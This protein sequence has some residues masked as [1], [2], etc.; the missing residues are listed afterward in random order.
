MQC[1]KLSPWAPASWARLGARPSPL[2]KPPKF[3]LL[4]DAVFIMWWVFFLLAKITVGAMAIAY[5]FLLTTNSFPFFNICCTYHHRMRDSGIKSLN[6]ILMYSHS[7]TIQD[8]T[9]IIL[10][11][12]Y[13]TH[14]YFEDHIM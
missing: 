12:P 5:T 8:R 7:S 13:N 9:N 2:E 4:L 11:L 10:K 6:L 3:V 14:S 1:V